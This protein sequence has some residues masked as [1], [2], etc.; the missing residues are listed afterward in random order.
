MHRFLHDNTQPTNPFNTFVEIP[1]TAEPPL[2]IQI[3]NNLDSIT[4]QINEI[5]SILNLESSFTEIPKNMESLYRITQYIPAVECFDFSP[6]SRRTKLIIISAIAATALLGFVIG[7]GIGTMIFNKSE[8]IIPLLCVGIMSA[9]IMS[10]VI[11]FPAAVL[12]SRSQCE[13]TLKEYEHIIHTM[14]RHTPSLY[15]IKQAISSESEEQLCQNLSLF[16]SKSG[17]SFQSRIHMI[18]SIIESIY[19]N[20]SLC[21]RWREMSSEIEAF[22][23]DDSIEEKFSHKNL[24]SLVPTIENVGINS[25]SQ[26]YKSTGQNNFTLLSKTNLNQSVSFKE[27]FHK[28]ISNIDDCLYYH[29]PTQHNIF[30]AKLL[31]L[32]KEA[33]KNEANHKEIDSIV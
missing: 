26:F 21:K 6:T 13:N 31:Q 28:L 22:I 10:S 30:Q 3:R 16:F 2:N 12:T 9:T 25:L 1:L 5:A 33:F 7:T 17:R 29:P 8:E 23:N 15:L 14:K 18:N 11:A 20:Y 27:E 19:P 4:T 24:A 32:E